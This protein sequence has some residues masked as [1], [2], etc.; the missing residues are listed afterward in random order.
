MFFVH[1]SPAARRRRRRRSADGTE[2]QAIRWRHLMDRT[3]TKRLF[4]QIDQS[5]SSSTRSSDVSTLHTKYS[6]ISDPSTYMHQILSKQPNTQLDL[7]KQHDIPSTVSVKKVTQSEIAKMT[8]IQKFTDRNMKEVTTADDVTTMPNTHT[9]RP[10][11][12]VSRVS[13]VSEIDSTDKTTWNTI[14]QEIPKRTSTRIRSVTMTQIPRIRSTRVRQSRASS[15][16]NVNVIHVN[17]SSIEMQPMASRLKASVS[18]NQRATNT[19]NGVT[20]TKL[21]RRSTTFK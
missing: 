7:K 10:M 1:R 17:R 4:T 8:N 13:R 6:V 14:R 18:L 5:N 2:Q 3:R 16:G 20:V 12:N 21:R 15:V 11:V 19:H 9:F